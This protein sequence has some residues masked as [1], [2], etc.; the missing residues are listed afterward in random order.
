M[1]NNQQ[2]MDLILNYARNDERI[3]AVAMNGSR[4]NENAP[5]D[6]FQDYDVVYLVTDVDS[7]TSDHSW[8]DYFG[9]RLIMQIPD[10]S[11]SDPPH[12]SGSFAYLMLFA[13]GNRIDLRLLPIQQCEAYLQE[14]KLTVLL[15]DK[16][17]SIPALPEPTDEDYRVMQPTA[18]QFAE[19]CN[20]FWWVSTY[21]AKGLWRREI[22]YALEHLDR[23][24]RPML[25]R[26]LSWQ[27]GDRHGWQI[28]IGKSGKYLDKYVS[29]EDWQALLAT[30]SCAEE[31]SVWQAVFAT[32]D[33]FSRTARQVA[34]CLGLEY[35]REEEGNV[36]AHLR[37][38][39]GLPHD[40]IRIYPD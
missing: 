35:N 34:S 19:C 40:A 31:E 33:L 9:E 3:R 11:T 4:V 14:D 13:D 22:L 23:Y 37:H 30:Y 20:E 39:A 12:P 18:V 7:F 8:V 26:M 38:I 1:R 17:G 21:I 2:M 25:I 28:S 32:I 27:A 15:L 5:E 36:T 16:D 6:P 29:A 10:N 24:V